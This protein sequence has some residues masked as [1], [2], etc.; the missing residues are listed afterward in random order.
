MSITKALSNSSP[1]S[2]GIIVIAD[3]NAASMDRIAAAFEKVGWSVGTAHNGDDA[4]DIAIAGK[5]NA[6]MLN[7]SRPEINGCGTCRKLLDLG[8]PIPTMMI[9]GC[10]DQAQASG[11]VNIEGTTI[12]LVSA[13]ELQEF[14][15]TA[16]KRF[17]W[18]GDSPNVVGNR[19]PGLRRPQ[20]PVSTKEL[21]QPE[22]IFFQPI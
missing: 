7:V 6:I 22:R 14:T 18:H 16:P 13:D 21:H 17:V 19:T 3:N 12:K 11:P 8:K 20:A 2:T 5:V 9:V 10:M 15:K 4:L 1:K